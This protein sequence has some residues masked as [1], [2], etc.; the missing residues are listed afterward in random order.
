MTRFLLLDFGTTSTKAAVADLDSGLFSRVRSFPSLPSCSNLPGRYEV[1]P[2][3]LTDR[4]NS[5]CRL[6]YNELPEPFAGIG[7]CSEQNGFVALSPANEPLTNYIS[8]KDERSLEPI[9]GLSTFALLTQE[10]GARFKEISG[11]RPGPGLPIMNA[12][13]LARSGLLT[14]PC[15]IATLPEWLALCSGDSCH[16]VHETMVHCQGFYDMRH[17][18]IS[19]ELTGLVEELTGLRCT[20]N[21]VADTGAVSGYWRSPNGKIPI[22][23]GVGDHQCSVLGACNVPRDSI[24]LNLGT[25]SQV[26]V[27]DPPAVREEFEVRPYF[28]A[29]TLVAVTRIPAGRALTDYLRFL[30]EVSVAAGAQ[31][32]DFWSM[33]SALEERDLEDAT[34]EFDLAVFSSAWNYRGGGRIGNIAEGSLTTKNYLASLF[35]S[36]VQQYPPVVR[37]F[38]PV[39]QANRCILSGGLARRLPSLARIFATLSGYETWPA[40]TLDESLLGLRTIALVASRRASS[41]LE[42]Q[43]VY[44]RKCAVEQ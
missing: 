37:L 15:K 2:T 28:D 42:A 27:I 44:G 33:F 11:W 7:L 35:K 19:A 34:L 41:C 30:E 14:G 6:Y 18:R 3:A 25:G 5:V 23:V 17:R 43:E 4:F 40:C 22:Y 31:Q 32:P 12:A 16:V 38:D 13:H 20:F 10:L 8:W 9:D 21:E 26:A 36:W 24:S 1:A 39:H 29:R